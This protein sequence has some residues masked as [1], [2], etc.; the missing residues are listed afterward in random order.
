[1]SNNS[2]K[3]ILTVPKRSFFLFGARGTGK[4]TWLKQNFP[5]TLYLDLL[6]T[7]L[8]LE[9]SQN[10]SRLEA[11]A[12]TLPEGA[13]IVIDEIQK[14]PELLNEV[15]RLIEGRKWNF[16]LS[17]SSARKLKRKGVDLLAG[18]A[19]TRNFFPLSFTEIKESFDLNF[20]LEWGMMPTVQTSRDEAADLLSAY[21]DTYIKEEIR[22]EGIIRKLSPFLRFMGVAGIL[23]GQIINSL[24]IAREAAVPRSNVDSYF[25]VLQDTLLGIFLPAYRPNL[26]IREQSHPK[27]YWFDP[28]VARAASGL[29]FQ[30]VDKLWLGTSLETFIFNELR[31]YNQLSSKNPAIYYYRTSSG[32]E[33]DF[34]IETRK[35]QLDSKAH[36]VCIEIK[37]SEKW[38][39]EW[40]KPIRS[41]N[42]ENNITVDKMIGVYTG[43][44]R[45]LFNNFHVMPVIDFIEELYAGN[46]F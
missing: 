2:I 9:L 12:C 27:F 38:K 3:R 21:V 28:G 41:F 35:R 43:N 44:Q 25:S 29:L 37:L 1:M 8:F 11:M 36:V 31:I 24:N 15:H 42:S 22:E 6:K 13:W 30:P 4:S 33:I 32:T 10:P 19:L 20:S 26:K 34:V 23:N 7:S 45:Y 17:G 18:R 5:D 40:E 39:N 14:I 16:A 46:I